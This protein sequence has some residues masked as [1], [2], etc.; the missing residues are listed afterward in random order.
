MS[1]QWENRL[2]E[3]A[4]KITLGE[5]DRERLLKKA[6]SGQKSIL[7][8]KRR[9]KLAAA[10]CLIV[11]LT[12]LVPEI[13][14]KDGKET[15]VVYAATKDGEWS[16]LEI[17]ERQQ[18]VKTIDDRG[19]C[20][21]FKV[22]LPEQYMFEQ[23]YTSIGEDAIYMYRGDKIR[24]ALW[25]D[26]SKEGTASLRIRIVDQD[27]NRIDTLELVMTKEKGECYAELRRIQ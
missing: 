27:G 20:C 12:L 16:R 2:R 1:E 13:S 7:V 6:I 18:L 25:D 21:L 26:S 23:S 22:D 10:L 19:E 3:A 14:L 4:K 17:G 24:W 8:I 9:F 11:I 15:V 5:A